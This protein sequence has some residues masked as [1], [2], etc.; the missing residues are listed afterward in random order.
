LIA[1]TA[2]TCQARSVFAIRLKSMYA[3]DLLREH[4]APLGPEVALG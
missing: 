2:K 4:L 3:A 1:P